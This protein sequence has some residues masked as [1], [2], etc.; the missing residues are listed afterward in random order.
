M[1]F[2]CGGIP[3]G[4]F[5]QATLQQTL[6]ATFEAFGN[7]D[8]ARAYQLTQQLETQFGREP[9]FRDPDVQRVLLPV[10]GYSALAAG[11]PGNAVAPFETFLEQFPDSR[12]A[13]LVLYALARA[14]RQ[15]G[16]RREAAETFARFARTFPNSNET[17]L[18]LMQRIELLYEMDDVAGA[19]AAVEEFFTGNFSAQLRFEAR[20]RMLQNAVEREDLNTAG[21]ILLE[22]S[23]AVDTMPEL[24]ILA[25]QALSIGDHFLRQERFADAVRAYRLVPPRNIL[26]RKQRSQI[27]FVR[28]NARRQSTGRSSGIWTEYFTN[29]LGRLDAQLTAL[30]AMEDYTGGFLLRLGQAYLLG[31]R[32]REAWL[33]F[34]GL[35]ED[36]S[37][38]KDLREQAHYRWILA[39]YQMGA[40]EEALDIAFEY[41][42]RYGDSDLAPAATFMVARTFQEMNRFADAIPVLTDLLDRFPDHPGAGEWLYTRG[43]NHSMLADY[44]LARRDFASYI[45][46]F[47]DGPYFLMAKFWHALSHHFERNNTQALAELDALLPLVQQHPLLPEVIYRRANVFYAMRDFDRAEEIIETFL[48][49]YFRHLRAPE[50]RVLLADIRMGQ[51]R[52]L[53]AA[54]LFARITPEADQ[55]FYYA[56]FQAGKIYRALEDYEGMIRHFTRFIEREDLESPQRISE[57]LY[58]IGWAYAQMDQPEQAF[59][60]FL[61]ALERFGDDRDA[62]EIQNIL[63]ALQTLHRRFQPRL[64]EDHPD[65][66][67]LQT[68]DFA[69]WLEAERERLW[70]ERR[71]THYGRINLFLARLYRQR[72]EEEVAR[73]YL[74]ETAGRVPRS[75]MDAELLAEIGLSLLDLELAAADRFFNELLERYPRHYER[76]AAFYAAARQLQRAGESEQA[77]VWVN[78]FRTETPM[79]PL[80]H[81]ATILRGQIE[82]DLERFDQAETTF[83]ELLRIRQARGRPH[84]EALAGLA[85]LNEKR[86]QI[87][88]AIPYWQRL[89][90]L[91][92][93]HTDLVF[94]AYLESSRLF[95]QL[96]DLPAAFRSLQEMM[97]ENRFQ[98]EPGF[99]RAE[100]EFQRL[101]TLVQSLETNPAPEGGASS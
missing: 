57:G 12:Q 19:E 87:E 49:S 77:L 20:L 48:R 33:L 93:T 21:R 39:A 60:V 71:R 72:G 46:S 75:R 85:V 82:I 54:D 56:V 42:D 24:A 70:E 6:N 22:T 28:E 16:E 50:A 97:R 63:T 74:F 14:Y 4:L 73:G 27:E 62:G 9:E 67:I 52:L 5:A 81:R 37:L 32:H 8:Y 2:L 35:A 26:I 30:E 7:G 1:L 15:T 98:G 69:V 95:E 96:G 44:P 17:P 80:A 51:G 78:R 13:Q 3:S 38:D 36:E 23:W 76:A 94:S 79:H 99:A 41:S 47:S 40:Y 43:F 91:Y 31:E 64:K 34:R 65:Q 88:R 92:R 66:P 90:T 100:A 10:A 89:Y 84:A 45:E 18:A 59:P 53:E 101:R 11:F 86:G 58:W 83:E 68:A 29:L 61:Q 25:F 55:L